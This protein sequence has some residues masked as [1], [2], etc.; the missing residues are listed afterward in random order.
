MSGF[1][2][3]ASA[4]GLFEAKSHKSTSKQQKTSK[5]VTAVVFIN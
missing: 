4:A 1:A 3:R 5:T 2:F